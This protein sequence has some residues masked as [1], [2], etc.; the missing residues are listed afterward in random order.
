MASSAGAQESADSARIARA[1]EA[2]ARVIGESRWTWSS[3]TAERQP[4]APYVEP[5]DAAESRRRFQ[6]LGC[7]GVIV[8]QPPAAP[9]VIV[10]PHDSTTLPLTRC[11]ER[12]TRTEFSR[13]GGQSWQAAI[14]SVR[15]CPAGATPR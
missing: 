6:Q 2:A 3:T 14:S 12:E 8:A 9:N 5:P 7:A 15:V 11:V 13:D 10:L 1:C 4:G